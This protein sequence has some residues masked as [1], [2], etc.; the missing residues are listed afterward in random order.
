MN[1]GKISLL[2]VSLSLFVA[3]CKKDTGE[4][5]NQSSGGGTTKDFVYGTATLPSIKDADGIVAAADVRNYRTLVI[6]PFEKRFQYGLAA[7]TN[8]TGDFSSLVTAGAITVDT[9]ALTASSTGLYQSY[10]TTYSLNFASTNIGWNVTGSGSVAAMTYN[11]TNPIPTYSL[12][13]SSTGGTYFTSYW[14][15]DWVP[16]YS[17]P[18]SKPAQIFPPDS[19][20]CDT[21][22]T[23]KCDSAEKA[24]IKYIADSTKFLLDS[25]WN[26]TIYM[27]IPV[28]GY[29][30]NG[31]SA[32]LKWHD[33]AGFSFEKKF[34]ATDSIRVKPNDFLGYPSY[35]QDAD[36]QMEISLVKY[37]SVMVG[38][39][40]YYYIRMT[41]FVKYWRL[42]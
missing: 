31:D 37:N 16:T 19:L 4:F 26:E 42:E 38:V 15:D 28:V 30:A 41:S 32:I 24:Y 35:Q 10:P 34:A 21:V 8:T 29:S 17:R 23:V 9:S 6:S 3:S 5:P 11:L 7:F 27:K 20:W 36:F 18:L 25:T 13:P 33:N 12:F 39:K 2:A 1:F 22:P 14:K 40:K